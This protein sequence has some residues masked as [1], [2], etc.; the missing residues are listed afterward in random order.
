MSDSSL[1]GPIT[2][3]RNVMVGMDWVTTNRHG[4]IRVKKDVYA[5]WPEPLINLGNWYSTYV[6]RLNY[7]PNPQTCR[8]LWYEEHQEIAIPQLLEPDAFVLFFEQQMKLAEADRERWEKIADDDPVFSPPYDKLWH[9]RS[10]NGWL[11]SART[12]RQL[13]LTKALGLFRDGAES[14]IDEIKRA[15]EGLARMPLLPERDPTYDPAWFEERIA[16][17]EGI[18]AHYRAGWP[19]IVERLLARDDLGD[20]FNLR[21]EWLEERPTLDLLLSVDESVPNRLYWQM[22]S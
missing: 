14:T 5:T 2:K 9:I 21:R 3:R 22:K 7:S 15:Q 13:F 10:A 6:E 11:G 8:Y 16:L 12:S 20:K 4:G 17:F 18:M 1:W 19:I